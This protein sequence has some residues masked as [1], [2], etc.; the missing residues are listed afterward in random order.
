MNM[1]VLTP[2]RKKPRPGDVFVFHVASIGFG[3]GRVIRTD[4][5]IGPMVGCILIYIYKPFSPLK[6]P[7]PEMRKEDLLV[8]PMMTNNQPWLRGYFETVATV[9]LGSDDVLVPHCFRDI[10]GLYFDESGNRL[11][12]PVPLCG[13]HGLHSFRTIDDVV[14]T[15]LGIPVS[16]D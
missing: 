3:F 14:S 9:P 12:A 5:R 7:L 1:V 15:A 6:F 4:A 16:P 8:A 2:T 13:E 10:R 11:S